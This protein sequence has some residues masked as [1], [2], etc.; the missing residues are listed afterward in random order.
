MTP[1]IRGNIMFSLFKKKINNQIELGKVATDFSNYLQSER[2]SV[3]EI[4][5]N[6]GISTKKLPNNPTFNQ[7]LNN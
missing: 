2:N 4:T 1:A 3:D 6:A 7:L 5:N